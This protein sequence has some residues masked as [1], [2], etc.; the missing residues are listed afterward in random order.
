MLVVP[1]GR[2]PVLLDFFVAAPGR[3]SGPDPARRAAAGPDL[4]RRRRAGVQHRRRL[5]RAATGCPPGSARRRGAS[6]ACRSTS[7]WRPAGRAG[8]RGRAADRRAGLHHRSCSGGIVTS[9]PE[10]AALFAPHGRLLRAGDR[11]LPARARRQPCERLGREGSRPFYEG[12]IG[13]AIA[14]W[15]GERGGVVSRADLAA[16][17]VID[18]EPIR[19]SYRGREVLTNPPPSPGGLLIARA[20]ALLDADRRPARGGRHRRRHGADPARA[21]APRS[22]TASTIPASPRASWPASPAPTPGRAAARAGWARPPTSRC[23]TREGWACSVTCSNGSAS[24]VVVPGHR[25]APQQHARRAGPQPA[26]AFTATRRA[27]G[28][29][30]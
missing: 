18:R 27:A 16:Y 25:R 7:S 8:P 10:C 11:M 19:V 30:A 17:G 20:L 13:A 12:D 9:T 23:S 1:P 26:T 5:G 29:R 24:G 28:C 4:L 14:D 3:E 22:W 2:A 6:G 21:H 15:L